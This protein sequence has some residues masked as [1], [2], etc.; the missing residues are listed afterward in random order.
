MVLK[1]ILAH[2]AATSVSGA[3]VFLDQKKAY[4]RVSHDY[5]FAVL[6][7][8]GFPPLLQHAF[9]S[10]FLNSTTYIL[11]DGQ[12]LGP[13]PVGCGVRQGDPL[14]PLLFN[15]CFEPLLATMRSRLQGI[16]LPWGTYTDSEYADDSGFGT[17]PD[18]GPAFTTTLDHYC[19]ASNARIN[20]FKSR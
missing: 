14:A 20:Y 7:R 16:R 2:A 1:S 9:A 8:F 17:H 6:S 18:D 11:D 5:L 10:T 12:P 4:D 3:L 15:L 19:A 13:I